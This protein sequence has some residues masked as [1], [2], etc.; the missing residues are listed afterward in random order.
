MMENY[1]INSQENRDAPLKNRATIMSF[2]HHKYDGKL[3]H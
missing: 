2:Q 3:Q 1:N